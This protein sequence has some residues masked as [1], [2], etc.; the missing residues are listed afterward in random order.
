MPAFYVATMSRYSWPLVLHHHFWL[1][2]TT[3]LFSPPDFARS[4]SLSSSQAAIVSAFLNRGIEIVQPLIGIITDRYGRIET[5]AVLTF[6]CG[7]LCFRSLASRDQLRYHLPPFSF[8]WSSFRC[9]LG[10]ESASRWSVCSDINLGLLAGLHSPSK[11][12][13]MPNF[14]LCSTYP[15]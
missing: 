11:S 12:P 4:I 14:L 1:Y 8:K 15:G 9:C 5:T 13:I 3:L 7:I 10:S 6:V 2:H